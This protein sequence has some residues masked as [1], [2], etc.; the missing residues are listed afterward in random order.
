MTNDTTT[1]ENEQT[2]SAVEQSQEQETSV[3]QEVSAKE[4]ES[5]I[6]EVEGDNEKETLLQ[7]TGANEAES[8]ISMSGGDSD[9]NDNK[10]GK[11]KDWVVKLLKDYLSKVN[12][13]E[14]QKKITFKEGTQFGENFASGPNGKGGNVDGNGQAEFRSLR[15]WEWLEVPEFRFNRVSVNVGLQIQAKG[16]G[17]IETVTPA[18]DGT[19]TGTLTLKL[20][21]GEYGAIEAGDF[22]MG[23]WHDTEGNSTATTD[24]KKGCYT[25]RGFKT[26][27]FYVSSVTG[28]NNNT[29]HY[30]LRS[31]A[32]GGNGFHPFAGMHFAQRGNDQNKKRQALVFRTPEYTLKLCD[33]STWEFQTSNYYEISGHVDG[34]TMPRA[35]GTTKTFEGYGTV[36]GNAYVFG[37]IDQFERAKYSMEAVG[38]KGEIIKWGEDFNLNVTIKNGYNQDVTDD[39]TAWT[40]TRN[41]GDTSADTSWNSRHDMTSKTITL[42]YLDLFPWGAYNTVQFTIKATLKNGN[43]VTVIAPFKLYGKGLEIVFTS[44]KGMIIK[45]AN[46]DLTLTAHLMFDGNDITNDYLLNSGANIMK[47]TRDSGD[48]IGD[49]DWVATTGTTDNILLL[50]HYSSRTPGKRQDMGVKWPCPVTFTFTAQIYFGDVPTAKTVSKSVSFK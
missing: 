1:T 31:K 24:D 15:V 20:E 37:T 2:S 16:G 7:E 36:L 29:V 34:F 44:D 25:L 27:Y 42:S 12:E 4:Q 26:I 38:D 43:T 9:I 48:E 10:L 23:L 30:V 21:D 19:E 46:V 18:T 8:D 3:L 14:A 32:D 6:A 39:V 50:E 41:T 40:I 35:N 17:I 5:N 11:L 49:K 33:V 28:D 13:D 22:C 47:W 45:S